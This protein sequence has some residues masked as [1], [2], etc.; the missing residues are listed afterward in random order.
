MSI[1]AGNRLARN[2]DIDTYPEANNGSNDK[3]TKQTCDSPRS[4]SLYLNLFRMRKMFPPPKYEWSTITPGFNVRCLL[5]ISLRLIRTHRLLVYRPFYRPFS[6]TVHVSSLLPM[7]AGRCS[8]NTQT[9][10]RLNE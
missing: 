5:F 4:A 10:Q 3:Q 9:Q 2:D 8:H 7:N 1:D 6:L